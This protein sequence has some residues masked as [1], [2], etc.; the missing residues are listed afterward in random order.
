QG[1][2]QGRR[3]RGATRPREAGTAAR[4]MEVARRRPPRSRP[5]C[6]IGRIW[7]RR[8][9]RTQTALRR[10]LPHR[11]Q[12]ASARSM[13][14]SL[15]C[16]QRPPVGVVPTAGSGGYALRLRCRYFSAH[17]I[18]SRLVGNSRQLRAS[19]LDVLARLASAA[20]R[21]GAGEVAGTGV[22]VPALD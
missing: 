16:R 7:A 14:R 18:T 2:G 6:P 12:R 4:T 8:R 15:E 21:A 17:L 10:A 13:A 9:T 11:S 22:A 20:T 3:E 5:R 1:P 19:A